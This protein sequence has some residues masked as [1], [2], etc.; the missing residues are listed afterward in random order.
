MRDI[1]II[2]KELEEARDENQ[3]AFEDAPLNL[4]YNGFM[5][6][7]KPSN[8]KVSRLSREYRMLVEPNYSELPDYGDVMSLSDFIESVKFGGFI[9]YDGSGNYVKD[10]KMSDIDIYPS[11][12][13]AGAIRKDFD[14]IIWF[15]R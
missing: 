15:N 14:T 12:Y 7:M 11:D 5:E 10:G 1:K 8:E 6:Y 4:D 9:D 3:K 2:K 13:K